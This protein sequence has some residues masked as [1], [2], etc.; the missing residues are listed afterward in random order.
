MPQHRKNLLRLQYKNLKLLKKWKKQ[1]KTIC[2]CKKNQVRCN[3]LSKFKKLKTELN[4]IKKKKLKKKM[5]LKQNVKKKNNPKN[6]KK[7]IM[8]LQINY[9]QKQQKITYF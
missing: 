9:N 2:I 4:K 6:C 8:K 1:N 7:I 5:C 3:K